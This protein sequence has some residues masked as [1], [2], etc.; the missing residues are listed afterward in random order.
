MKKEE[1]DFDAKLTGEKEK[2]EE[3]KQRWFK[4]IKKGILT[5]T[6]EKKKHRKDFGQSA[7]NVIL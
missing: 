4:R 2:Q 5:T 3:A 7:L 1:E 6:S